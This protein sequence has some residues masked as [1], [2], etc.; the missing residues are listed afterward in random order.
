M[1]NREKWSSFCQAIFEHTELC[2]R[3]AYLNKNLASLDHL[4]KGTFIKAFL[5]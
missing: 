3:Y 2:Q 4:K 1:M 5:K